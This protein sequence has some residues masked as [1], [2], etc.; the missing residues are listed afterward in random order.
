MSPMARDEHA[1]IY[2]MAM[3]LMVYFERVVRKFIRYHK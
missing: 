2:K 3:D 1:A